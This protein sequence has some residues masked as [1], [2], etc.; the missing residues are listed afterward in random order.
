MSHILFNP[1]P[2]QEPE[3]PFAVRYAQQVISVQV[4][5][6]L[7]GIAEKV[8]HM[9]TACELIQHPAESLSETRIEQ[10]FQLCYKTA[11]DGERLG[12]SQIKQ[13]LSSGVN[14]KQ[15]VLGRGWFFR[16]VVDFNDLVKSDNPPPVVA[17]A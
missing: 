17:D 2:K 4:D 1:L 8:P 6:Y 10:V 15:D 7:Q 9:E 5:T 11:K 14:F 13:E 3:Q 16:A 12:R